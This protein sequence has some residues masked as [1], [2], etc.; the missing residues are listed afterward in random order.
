M[1]PGPGLLGPCPGPVGPWRM[2][3]EAAP[4]L[5]GPCPVGSG[6]RPRWGFTRPL[7]GGSSSDARWDSHKRVKSD[8]AESESRNSTSEKN[9]SDAEEGQSEQQL[10]AGP[11][12]AV[13]SPHLSQPPIPTLLL[14]K[15]RARRAR[16]AMEA[17][18]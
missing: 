6:K 12:F 18:E 17:M 9:G 7:G 16:K 13:A 2:L 8:V 3:P 14:A 5:L 4:G 1:A 15:V 11:G 10:Y